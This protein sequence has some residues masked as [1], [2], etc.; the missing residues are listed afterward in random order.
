M[1]GTNFSSWYNQNEGTVF[2]DLPNNLNS[3]DN[4]DCMFSFH[5]GSTNRLT[6]QWVTYSWFWK[7]SSTQVTINPYVSSTSTAGKYAFSFDSS[8][9]SATYNAQTVNTVTAGTLN[10]D[11]TGLRFFSEY[12]GGRPVYGHLS[13]FT[14]YP[15]RLT[16]A[17]LQALTL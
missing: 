6:P 15:T 1:P 16:D 14:Y 5:N 10:Q 13:R 8:D 2:I 7:A 4:N 17:Q 12:N 9:I 3:V 11:V